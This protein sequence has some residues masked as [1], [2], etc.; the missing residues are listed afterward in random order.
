MTR[1]RILI[2][3]VAAVV[4]GSA[5]WPYLHAAEN[6]SGFT[7]QDYMEIQNLYGRYVRAADMGGGGGRERLGELLHARWRVR[8]CQRP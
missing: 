5:V 6:G 1:T 2:A 8:H 4:L 3:A 7:P